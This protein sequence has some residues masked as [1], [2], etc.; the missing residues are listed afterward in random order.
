V[1]FHTFIKRFL[2]IVAKWRM[3][4]IM[5]KRRKLNDIGLNRARS[6]F[7]TSLQGIDLDRDR[8]RNLSNL[9]RVSKAI[10]IKVRFISWKYLRLSLKPSECRR[11]NQ[12][13]VV[14]PPRRPPRFLN[15]FFYFI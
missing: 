13:A 1:V 15:F 10:A 5:S 9:K 6:T 3:P 7:E 12:S 2:A 4:Q 14:T 8:L 11:M